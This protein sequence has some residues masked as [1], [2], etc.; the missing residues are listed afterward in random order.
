MRNE[1]EVAWSSHRRSQ[2]RG[3]NSAR[4]SK[5]RVMLSKEEEGRQR[6]GDRGRETD[7]VVPA[8]GSGTQEA[9]AG[10]LPFVQG[11][12]GLCSNSQDILEL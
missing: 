4:E 11:Q 9:E 6:K 10:Q 5:I 7:V 2:G 1:K 8:C 3:E 12:H